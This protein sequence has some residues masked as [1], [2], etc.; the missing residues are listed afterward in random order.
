MQKTQSYGSWQSPISAEMVGQGTLSFSE[1]TLQNGIVYWLEGRPAEQGRVALMSWDSRKGEQELLPKDYSVR[2]RVHEYGGGALLIGQHSIYFV[3]ASDQQIYSLTK[4]TLVIKKISSQPDTRFADGCIDPI[5]GSLFFVMEEHKETV[6][7]SIVTIDPTT[8]NWEP[9]AHGNDFYAAPRVSPD[10]KTLSYI[11][12]NHPNLPWDSTQLWTVDLQTNTQQLIAGNNNESITDPKWAPDGLLYYISDK[13]NWWNIYQAQTARNV[14]PIDAECTLPPWFL[15]RSLYGFS[16]HGIVVVYIKKGISNFALITPQ[17]VTAIDLPYPNVKWLAVEDNKIAFIAGCPTLPYSII[18]Y[19]L[20]TEQSRIIKSVST[21]PVDASFFSIPQVIEFPCADNRTA[22]GFYYPPCNPEFN[23]PAGELPP[24]IVRSHGGPTAQ[25]ALLLSLE[26]LYWTSRGFAIMDVN[27]GGST[28]YGRA[29]RESLYGQWGIIDVADCAHA[30]LYCVAHGLADKNRL[31]I[32]GASAGGFTTLASL[33]S[34]T[35]FK[36]G[37]NYYGVSD[38]E[39]LTLET[40]K[41]QSHYLDHLIGPY[42]AQRDLYLARSPIN[43][44]DEIKSPLI[45]FQGDKDTIVPQNQSEMMYASLVKRNIPCAYIVYEGEGHG[46]GKSKNI[47]R[48][49]EA[50][51]YFFS[52]IFNFVL[53]ENI[54]PVLIMN[55]REPL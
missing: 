6:N 26:I 24:L 15:G 3:N 48:T 47:T 12:W 40:H 10:G 19:N 35:I 11:T 18:E 52:K 53:S 22:H 32:E 21:L 4:D 2:S 16:G 31:I 27:Y 46:F 45:I 49:I 17:K 1:V 41:F 55:L 8:G 34:D 42:P 14:W 39:R 13:T 44:A 33:S 23:A 51:L 25:T 43:H 37:V 29:Y 7:N 36:A 28:G 38:L 30:A 5:T 20:D 54:E 9:V 50:Q